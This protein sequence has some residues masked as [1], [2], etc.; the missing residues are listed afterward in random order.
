MRRGPRDPEESILAGG[1]WQHALWVG[2]LMAAVTIPLEAVARAFDWPWQTMVFTTLA[3]LQLG[4]AYAVRA[5][6]E[7]AFRLGMRTNPWIS[8]AIAL[9]VGAQLA[10]V[11][12]PGLQQVFGTES[13]GVLQLGIVGLASTAALAAVEIEKLFRR[14]ARTHL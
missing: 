3:F 6:R 1:L 9:G 4:H 14:R 8:S 2:L 13:L 7:S 10:T 11:Y 12:M 5:E